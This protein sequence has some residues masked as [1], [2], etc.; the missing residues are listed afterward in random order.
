MWGRVGAARDASCWE[1]SEQPSEVPGRSCI[2][3]MSPARK[4][5]D[6]TPS[7]VEAWPGRTVFLSSSAVFAIL[8][9]RRL[10]FLRDLWCWVS[11]GVANPSEGKMARGA[12]GPVVKLQPALVLINS[13]SFGL[14]FTYDYMPPLCEFRV[15]FTCQD[16]LALSPATVAA[17]HSYV[18]NNRTWSEAEPQSIALDILSR[19]T[20]TAS[21]RVYWAAW[22][23]PKTCRREAAGCSDE[24][25]VTNKIRRVQTTQNRD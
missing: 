1:E 9:M 16:M 5:T 13:C 15:D 21:R 12:L 6:A 8:I 10:N 17:S 14:P 4:G 3:A 25:P 11:F 18:R 2:V 7:G 20:V 22:E 23:A 24:S 19:S